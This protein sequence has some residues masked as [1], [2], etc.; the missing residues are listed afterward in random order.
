VITKSLPFEC[1]V[2][3][4]ERQ[5]E[6]YASTFGNKDLVD[7][8]MEKGCYRKSIA[9]RGPNGSNDIKV[10][11]GHMEPFGMPL[12]L[13][14]D[15]HGLYVVGQ[16]SDTHENK[17]RLVYMRDGVVKTMSVGFRIP[18]GKAWF[19]EDNWTRHIT[20]AKLMEFSPVMF[21]ANEEAII[22][23]VAK[24]QQ[25]ATLVKSFGKDTLLKQADVMKDVLDT[26]DPRDLDEVI[27]SLIKARTL[28]FG[29]DEEK[30]ALKAHSEPLEG[31]RGRQEPPQDDADEAKAL[32]DVLG[33]LYLGSALLG[34]K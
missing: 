21:P 7:D 3:L 10:L 34:I 33:E 27:E 5:F 4:G 25:V 28:L 6:G 15:D 8:I 13:H 1:K 16:A 17:D 24:H 31:T 23:S 19:E 18:E 32:Q 9:E 11:W 12:E 22:S 14:E 2:N 20:E 29:T 30:R 26:V